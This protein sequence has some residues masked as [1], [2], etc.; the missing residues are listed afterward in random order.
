MVLC[1]REK[2]VKMN[3][4][5]NLIRFITFAPILVIPLITVLITTL[6]I[7]HNQDILEQSLNNVRERLISEQKKSIV[8]KTNMAIELITYQR[9][10]IQKRLQTKVKSRVDSAYAVAHSIYEKHRGHKSDSE[11]QSMIVD[12]LR[13]MVWNNGESFIFILDQQGR[14]VL[15]PNYLRHLEGKSIIDFQDVTGRYVIQEEIELIKTK[16]EGFLWD[17]FTRPNHDPKIQ[18]KQLAYVR[19]MNHYN[20]YMGS[21]EY[22]DTTTKEIE[23]AS[24]NTLRH[25]NKNVDEYFFI[26]D[27][28]GKVIL[29]PHNTALEGENLL[30]VHNGNFS[31]IG[32]E[33]LTKGKTHDEEFSEYRWINPKNGKMETKIS[34][35]KM[36]PQSEWVIGTGF[37]VEEIDN[38]VK[39]KKQKLRSLYQGEI[40]KAIAYSVLFLF[41]SLMVSFYVSFRLKRH[42]S[43][44]HENIEHHNKELSELNTTLEEKIAQRTEELK[45]AHDYMEKLAMTD[46]LTGIHNRYAFLNFLAAEESESDRHGTVF[47]LIMFDL[48]DFKK[49]NDTYGHDKG[50][51]V[52]IE[53]VKRVDV[54]LRKGDLFG[55]IGGEEF[56]VLLRHTPIDTA[57][58]IAQRIR[59]KVASEPFELP[60]TVSIS[61]GVVQY[62]AHE[63]VESIMKRADIALYKAKESGKNRVE[64]G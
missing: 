41:I 9:S 48:D 7:R 46:A 59:E 34:F 55:R 33:F 6:S 23:Q 42:F 10:T 50:D 11:I 61:A 30:K 3:N 49:I 29:N 51:Q 39:I 32:S 1:Q 22:L 56:M 57:L 45:I 13:P 63:S 26:L 31:K 28:H 60:E 16:G 14:F 17:T 38:A 19:N 27:T 25:I 21:S 8:S 4:E 18:Y 24:I 36:I 44:L 37:Y 62:M 20:W 5:K 54:C 2:W 15:A 40:K 12:A 52:L 58:E 43:L 64:L 53:V 47:S 35:V